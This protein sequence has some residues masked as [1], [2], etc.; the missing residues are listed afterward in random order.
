MISAKVFSIIALIAIRVGAQSPQSIV[1]VPLPSH[2]TRSWALD[3]IDSHASLYDGKYMPLGSGLAVTVYVFDVGILQSHPEIR[4]RVRRLDY[5]YYKGQPQFC[6]SHGTAVASAIA[7][8]TL[9][10]APKANIVDVKVFNCEDLKVGFAAL[11]GAVDKVIRDHRGQGP[12]VANFSLYMSDSGR[13]D[14]VDS[15][16]DHLQSAGITVVVSAGN[17]PKIDACTI[18]P[19]NSP[20]VISVGA[21]EHTWDSV[22]GKYL[23]KRAKYSTSGPCVSLYAPGDSVILASTSDTTD[24]SISFG[25]SMGAGYVSGAAALYLELH[26]LATPAQVK[27]SLIEN[28]TPSLIMS[29]WVGEL[30]RILYVGVD[31]TTHKP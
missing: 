5:E 1:P 31:S 6:D 16:M 22:T 30:S 23:D 8:S 21:L 9:G 3:R 25:T 17:F 20:G 18:S 13:V 19:G 10:V 26:P 27:K 4:G 29:G 7:G 12:A 28:A 11:A 24:L 14:D 15:L 2:G